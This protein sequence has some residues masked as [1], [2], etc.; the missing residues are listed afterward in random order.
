M[1]NLMNFIFLSGVVCMNTTPSLKKWAPFCFCYNFVSRD[2]ILVFFG[3]LVAKEICNR[4]LF[5]YLKVIA[6]TL[7]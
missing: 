5:T 6:G 4:P 2:Q 1:A 3:S 7:R